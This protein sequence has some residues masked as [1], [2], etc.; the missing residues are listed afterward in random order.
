MVY[1]IWTVFQW[2]LLFFLI[3]S[4]PLAAA[5]TIPKK[6]DPLPEFALSTPASAPDQQYL[7]IGPEATF[8]FGDIQAKLVMIETVGVYC[9]Q[10]HIQLPKINQMHG[11][12]SKDAALS[13]QV[14]IMAIAA[15]ATPAEADYLKK[16]L[17]IPYPVISDPQFEIHKVLGEPRTPF[18][19]IVSRDGSIVFTHLG[20]LTNTDQLLN[21]IRSLAKQ[22]Q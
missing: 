13:R 16:Q 20:P 3:S 8:S 11:I 18:N 9:P 10:C 5:N 21:Q 1:R 2:L 7:G 14:K 22:I 19:M 17:N 4:L 15:G 6:G 12:I